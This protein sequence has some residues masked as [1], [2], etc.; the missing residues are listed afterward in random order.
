MNRQSTNQ[1]SLLRLMFFI[2]VSVGAAN[3]AFCQDRI[4]A[5]YFEPPVRLEADGKPI[6]IGQHYPLAHAGPCIADYDCDGD[7][8]LVVGSYS[9]TFFLFENTGSDSSPV[10]TFSGELQAGDETALVPIY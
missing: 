4:A 1:I 8:D 6:D 7:R 2:T 5:R 3:L 9:G 10:Y